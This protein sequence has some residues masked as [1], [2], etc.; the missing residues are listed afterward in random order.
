MG[1]SK[2]LEGGHVFDAGDVELESGNILKNTELVYYTSG[3]LSETLDNAILINTHFGGTHVNSQYLIGNDMALNPEKY[4]IVIVNLLGNGMSTSPSHGTGS[5]FPHVSIADNVKVQRRLLFEVFGI[6]DLALVLGHSMGGVTSFH[7][8]TLFPDQVKRVAPICG[9]AKIS[10]HNHVF[11]EGMKGI[12]MA[13]PIWKNGDYEDVPLTGL[14]TMARAWAAWPPSSHFYREEL[15]KKLDFTSVEDF[16]DRYWEK[17][18][19]NLD[20]NDVLAQIATWQSADISRDKRYRGNFTEALKAITAKTFVIPCR[21]DAYFPPE[22]SMIEVDN[23]S[24]AKLFTIDSSWGHWAGSGRNFADTTF[25]D[26]A[27]KK[28]LDAET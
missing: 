3:K 13:D 27:L 11:L 18:Y 8:A 6:T 7:W 4:F 16:L 20:A 14:K 26:A 24:G 9:A 10:R 17:T 23:I 21:T 1:D 25:I 19:C 2:S 5:K 28:L 22:D 12:L 15:Y